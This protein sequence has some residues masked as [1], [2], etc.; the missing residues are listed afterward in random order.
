VRKTPKKERGTYNP[1]RRSNPDRGGNRN[2][3]PRK[4]W[5]C[6]RF[7]SRGRTRKR[8][9]QERSKTGKEVPAAAPIVQK[10]QLSIVRSVT[11]Q[12]QLRGN[13]DSAYKRAMSDNDRNNRGADEIGKDAFSDR[14]RVIICTKGDACSQQATLPQTTSRR[15]SGALYPTKPKKHAG[16]II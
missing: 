5:D 6:Q 3:V 1:R 11:S 8:A 12:Q 13:E 16:V 14:V 9:D 2:I 7:Q 10:S 4:D 15:H